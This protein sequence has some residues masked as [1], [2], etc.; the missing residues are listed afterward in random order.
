MNC[1]RP[2]CGKRLLEEIDHHHF[3]SYRCLYHGEQILTPST[4]TLP[5]GQQPRAPQSQK[6]QERTL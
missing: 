1:P 2:A 5:H 3:R 6:P 4:A